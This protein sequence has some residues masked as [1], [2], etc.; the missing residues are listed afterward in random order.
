MF[1]F[2]KYGVTLTQRGLQEK[3]KYVKLI[4]SDDVE[5]IVEKKAAS[6][7][8]TIKQMLTSDGEELLDPCRCTTHLTI[9]TFD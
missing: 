2:K 1:L 7:S 9:S 4:S 3:E 5:F 6:V 8:S